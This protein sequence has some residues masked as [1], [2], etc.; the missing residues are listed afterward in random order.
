M[1]IRNAEIKLISM[2]ED[3]VVR[4]GFKLNKNNNIFTRNFNATKQIY[5]FYFY[6]S[7]DGVLVEPNVLIKLN[8]IEK[9]YRH[10]KK[11]FYYYEQISIGTSLGKIINHYDDGL[12][13]NK[14]G[15]NYY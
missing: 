4:N 12:D 3:E 13:V 15:N 6:K 8:S 1:K 11:E 5:K 9:I 7:Q 14:I 10:V 2:I